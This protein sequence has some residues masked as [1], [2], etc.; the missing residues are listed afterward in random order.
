MTG[1]IVSVIWTRFRHCS[2]IRN[3]WSGI[4]DWRWNIWK[5]VF[6]FHS[7]ATQELRIRWHFIFEYIS[8]LTYSTSKRT[9]IV[10]L[11]EHIIIQGCCWRRWYI[12]FFSIHISKF[13]PT[14]ITNHIIF[15]QSPE[16]PS[17]VHST[18]LKYFFQLSY[19]LQF[20]WN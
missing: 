13:P 5:I 14:A 12:L 10:I 8:Y 15:I 4:T 1:I 11:H 3:R 20:K 2:S 9:R 7:R 16:F 18:S 6:H 17:Q 19:H